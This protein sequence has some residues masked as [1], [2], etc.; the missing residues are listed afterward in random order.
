MTEIKEPNE[1]YILKSIKYLFRT[2]EEKKQKK[3]IYNKTY[4]QKD[5]KKEIVKKAVHKCK[6]KNKY[7]YT[8][9]CSICDKTTRNMSLHRKS[10]LHIANS[11]LIN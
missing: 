2:D 5:D 9:F 3:Q 11:S 1:T 7:Y 4:Y 10:K 6:S 8:Y